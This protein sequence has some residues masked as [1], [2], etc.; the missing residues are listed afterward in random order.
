MA[1]EVE[2]TIDKNENISVKKKNNSSKITIIEVNNGENEQAK[3][4]YTKGVQNNDDN[5]E[6]TQS[7]DINKETKQ[8]IYIE[9]VK[10]HASNQDDAEIS[11]SGK[12]SFD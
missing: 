4:N 11:E 9:N 5:I 2:T 6:A 8:N 7:S 3:S 1:E 10:P 12:L